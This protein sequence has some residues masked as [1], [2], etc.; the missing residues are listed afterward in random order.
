MGRKAS[1]AWRSRRGG[2]K[3]VETRRGLPGDAGDTH[4]RYLEATVKGVRV[5]S[6]YHAVTQVDG[7]TRVGCHAHVRRY[8]WNAR[9]TALIEADQGLD[10]IRQMYRFNSRSLQAMAR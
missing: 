6:I 3:P 10:F 7:R 1:M 9:Q 5:A 2:E 4:S 8:F